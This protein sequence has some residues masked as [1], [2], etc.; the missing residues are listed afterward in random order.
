MVGTRL[1][2]L[3]ALLIGL[4]STAEAATTPRI[5]ADPN[6]TYSLYDSDGR[7]CMYASFSMTFSII[8][9]TGNDTDEQVKNRDFYLPLNNK[10]DWIG[11]ECNK[12]LDLRWTNENG[13]ELGVALNFTRDENQRWTIRRVAFSFMVDNSSFMAPLDMDTHLVYQTN[14]SLT[15]LLN[16][17]YNLDQYFYC[18]R[19]KMFYL[20]EHG[21]MSDNDSLSNPCDNSSN[22][23][24]S[25]IDMMK[26]VIY[27]GDIVEEKMSKLICIE[28]YIAL[29]EIIVPVV[30]GGILAFLLLL[31]FVSYVIAYFRRRT[32]ESRQYEPMSGDI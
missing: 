26:A 28:D 10:M 8:Y 25:S 9:A 16:R 27:P 2:A 13:T 31:I 4:S 17:T 30:V 21:D 23:M 1:C 20:T 22:L 7:L 11:G 29:Q 15:N 14:H 12:S 3:A 18:E 19:C 6:S 5:I 32:K 24:C